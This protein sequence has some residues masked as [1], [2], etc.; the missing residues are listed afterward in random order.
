MPSGLEGTATSI[1]VFHSDRKEVLAGDLIGFHVKNA[2]VKDI[3]RGMVACDP[4]S[5]PCKPVIKF[6]AQ[7]IILNHPGQLKVGYCPYFFCH[8]SSFAGR[9]VE[10]IALVDRKTGKTIEEKPAGIK[11]G[12]AAIVV[13]EPQK[14]IVVEP[15]KDVPPLG[16]FAIRDLNITVAVGIVKA[17]EHT[18]P[19]KQVKPT[20]KG[21]SKFFHKKK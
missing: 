19:S 14:P 8:T 18:A 2:S 21:Q 7:I 3:E 4:T 15:F 10:I 20:G 9:F 17:V 13:V 5:Q 16:R 1:E 11:S 6:T 12:E